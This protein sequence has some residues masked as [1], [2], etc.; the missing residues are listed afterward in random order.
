[1]CLPILGVHTQ[2]TKGSPALPDD[3]IIIRKW[4][5]YDPRIRYLQRGGGVGDVTMF[6]AVNLVQFYRRKILHVITQKGDIVN[7]F[8]IVSTYRFIADGKSDLF[9]TN[10]AYTTNDNCIMHYLKSG[11]HKL[12]ITT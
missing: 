11:C 5:R 1:M 4:C 2:T 8:S 6:G 10:V 7:F 9:I 12:T 3:G